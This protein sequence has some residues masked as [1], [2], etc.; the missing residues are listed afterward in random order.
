MLDLDVYYPFSYCMGFE[1]KF[2]W[3]RTWKLG[4]YLLLYFNMWVSGSS[5]YSSSFLM[6]SGLWF[7]VKE[8]C[9]GMFTDPSPLLLTRD[10]CSYFQG[11]QWWGAEGR[12]TQWAVFPPCHVNILVK[13]WKVDSY[14]T[15]VLFL[16]K[17]RFICRNYCPFMPFML[18]SLMGG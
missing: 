14:H 16:K 3:S 13:S 1:P 12:W 7:T 15:K 8:S 17:W 5:V 6:L 4:N 10:E 11:I 2:R 9:L 18:K